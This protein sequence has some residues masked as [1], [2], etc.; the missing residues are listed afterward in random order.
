MPFRKPDFFES[1]QATTI[2][3]VR[4]IHGLTNPPANFFIFSLSL[5]KI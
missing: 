5:S 4:L 1:P 3:L 2:A